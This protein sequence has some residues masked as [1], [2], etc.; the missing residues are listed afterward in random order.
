[1]PHNT[2]ARQ[3]ARQSGGLTRTA[4]GG[5]ARYASLNS[6]RTQYSSN[7]DVIKDETRPLRMSTAQ[8]LGTGGDQRIAL[9]PDGANLY[10][11]LTSP[12]SSLAYG[13][14]TGSSVSE[15]G[16][17]SAEKLRLR[18]LSTT[19]GEASSKVYANELSRIRHELSDLCGLNGA[20]GSDII[21]AASGT[22]I[23]LIAPQ[24]TGCE[25]SIVVEPSEIG[26]GIPAA[27]NGLHFSSRAA[28]SENVPVGTPIDNDHARE[29]VTILSREP[30]GRPR[31]IKSIDAEVEALVTKAVKAGQ[32]VL[33]TIVDV[34]KT[35]L[36]VPS[37]A[38]AMALRQRYPESIDVLVDACQ[39]RLSPSTVRAYLEQGFLVAMTGSKFVTGPAFSGALFVP[40]SA[41]QRMRSCS[42]PHGFASYSS[43]HDWPEGWAA[44]ASLPDVANF[45]LL[46]RWEAALTELRTFLTLPEAEVK[47]FLKKF[48]TAVQDRLASDPAFEML[49][50][51]APSR[52]FSDAQSWDS[53]PTIFPFLLRHAD[54]IL[55]QREE[56]KRVYELL[57]GDLGDYSSSHNIM[58]KRC[59]VG[60]PVNCGTREEFSIS[61]LRL[62]A[63]ARLISDA[64]QGRGAAAVIS[65]ALTVLDK[66]ARLAHSLGWE[67]VNECCP[68]QTRR[69][70]ERG[71]GSQISYG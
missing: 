40:R 44:R 25:K 38:C 46:M 39:F 30:D 3:M 28:L 54:G 58:K 35:G 36:I 56:T 24:L 15:A 66:A 65:D 52:P 61:A 21:F 49:S 18:L 45:G 12:D 68:N 70:Y 2:Q 6:T 51:P 67:A 27:L 20:S 53:V 23:Y 37:P 16:Y 31:D 11:L 69:G 17:S 47:S 29:V 14:S 34:S 57:K 33:L 8:L 5:H 42:L 4:V 26:S 32:K 43:R 19:S 50:T 48:A 63:S 22:D 41:A 64:L 55:L 1:V 13:S 9:G 71:S 10:G 7:R 59:Q 62:C 60:Q